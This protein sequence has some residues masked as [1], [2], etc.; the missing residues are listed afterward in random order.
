MLDHRLLLLDV[1]CRKGLFFPSLPSSFSRTFSD[2]VSLL[3]LSPRIFFCFVLFC[4]FGGKKVC[5]KKPAEWRMRFFLGQLESA[6]LLYPHTP[7]KKAWTNEQVREFLFSFFL[8]KNWFYRF[9]CPRQLDIINANIA[10]GEVIRII[11]FAGS[12]KTSTMAELVKRRPDIKFLYLVFN[13]DAKKSAEKIF[14][15]ETMTFHAL[16][17][18]SMGISRSM[19]AQKDLTPSSVPSQFSY[20]LH[21][22]LGN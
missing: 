2:T 10:P 4:F 21:I 8:T 20:P 17:Y 5:G 14:P 1:L 3:P 15:C 16:A 18:K 12:G 22:L 9:C 19:V 11:A 7:Q 6:P 13:S